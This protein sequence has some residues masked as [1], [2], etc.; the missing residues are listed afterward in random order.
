MA[1]PLTLF[2]ISFLSLLWAGTVLSRTLGDIAR[3][4]RISEFVA[5]FILA[6]F[7]T[8]IPELFVAVS[9]TLQG[10]PDLS[11]AAIIGSNIA[12]MTIVIGLS[13][14]LAGKASFTG[15]ISTQNYWLISL[16]AFL[17]L[18]LL[19]DGVLSR[20]DGVLLLLA[21]GLYIRK[22]FKDKGYF[23]KPLDGDEKAIEE[24]P[25]TPF[26][27]LRLFGEFGFGTVVLLLSS[28]VL[29][30]SSKLIVGEYFDANFVLFGIIFI[31]LG[32]S[33]PEIAFGIR[34]TSSGHSS[35]MLGN[36]LGSVA[37]NAAGIIGLVAIIRPIEADFMADYLGASVFLLIS[38]IVFHFFARTKGHINR[39][40]GL[41]LVLLYFGFL[42]YTFTV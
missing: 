24:S 11:L 30:W 15:K 18:L 31:A 38:F 35:A 32:T 12:N 9:S 29:I 10:V 2:V 6:S 39:L 41:F 17:P 13:V 4:L 37:F 20:V 3:A 42:L 5:A 21:F 36:A 33:L 40:E 25:A 22:L 19:V 26:K 7:A 28:L 8:S 16:I 14:L 1:F 34:A 23:K 27:A